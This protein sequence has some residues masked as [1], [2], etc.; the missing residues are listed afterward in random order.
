MKRRSMLL[1][2]LM[3]LLSVG[4]VSADAGNVKVRFTGVEDGDKAVLSIASGEYLSTL[5]VTAD[6]SYEFKDVP[7]GRHSVKAEAPGYNVIEA[8][9]VVVNEDGSVIP[10]E[11]LRVAI[12]KQSAD[13]NE[14]NFTWKEDDSPAGYTTTSYINKPVEIDFLGKKIVPSGVPS[15]NILQNQYHILL[16][17]DEEQWT[18]EYAYR[19]V[20][21][22]KTLPG[23]Y[24]DRPYA[25]FTLTSGHIADD[26]TVAQ[27]DG[28]YEV[29]ISKDAFYYA[30]PFLV[31][32]DGV[33]GRL[34]S[35]RLH[36]AM[37]NFVTDFGRDEGRVNQI[38]SERFGCQIQ[39]V[40]YEELTR[41]ITDEDAGRFQPFVPSELVAIINMFEELPEGFHK[42]PHLNYL[43]RRINGMKHPI[44]P[45]AAAV[46][47][48]VDNG[49]IEFM[50]N[51]FG[52]NNQSFDTQRLILHEK[53]HFLWAY[54]FSE[55]IRRDWIKVGGWYED[56]NAGEGWSTTKDVE[57]VSAYAHAKNPNEDMAES[58]AFYLKN[59]DKL[60]SRSLEKYEFIRDRIMHGT[61][62]I[63]KIPDH[64]TFEVLN[65][66]PDYDYP[67][68]IKSVD[69]SVTGAPEED[70]TIT[71]QV[72]L[73][74]LDGF[75]DGASTGIVRITGP[76]FI[77]ENGEIHEQFVDLHLN[78]IDG[79]NHLL[80][81][82]A[83][84]S[85]YS[86]AGHW[87]GG[88]I[89]L[90]D[91]QGN[92]RFEGRND[93]VTDYYI[94]NPLEDLE[95][96]KYVGD[97]RYIL[98]D[99]IVEG[100]KAQNLQVRYK[101]TDNI[102]IRSVY[103]AMTCSAGE[104]GYEKYGYYDE[105]N[106]EGVVDFII[107]EYF[108]TGDYWI[109]NLFIDDFAGTSKY[110]TFSDSP[111][112]MPIQKIY[113]ETE[114]P[115][116][117]PVEIDLNRITVYAEPT[118]P[119]APDGETLV[120]I[121]FY[122]R[123]DKSGFGLCTYDLRD[124]QGIDHFQW[125][126]HRNSSNMFFDGDPT[127]WER[128]TIKCVLPQGS[129]PGIW[130]L[131]DITPHDKAGN[132][133]TY[134]F[135]ETLIFEPDDSDSDYVLFSELD[136]NDMLSIDLQGTSG[137]MFGFTWRIIHEESGK[138]INGASDDF[139]AENARKARL[140]SVSA[141]RGASVDV[142]ALDDGDL[143][144]IVTAL[145]AEGKVVAVKTKRLLKDSRSAIDSVIIGNDTPVTVYNLQGIAV[146]VNVDANDWQ[147]GLPA[148]IYIVDG[149][150]YLIK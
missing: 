74:H 6:G 145:N 73:N 105:E 50:E 52:G 69:I 138:E 119:E 125:F 130:G 62:Y 109:S 51:A 117:T 33:R 87:S 103:C 140:R 63:S 93:C 32:L 7:A 111:Q 42:T 70:K 43:I 24:Y 86:K 89:V 114:N 45:E 54:T 135:V 64:L 85:R 18:Q 78:P 112:D 107:T 36:H 39:N 143:I 17:D 68:K 110:V 96:P 91:M 102:G 46:S 121:N 108:P 67:G 59:P 128:Y 142:S 5:T 61:R 57:F 21:T 101:T 146:K 88:D 98:T 71:L 37:T 44:Y 134:N 34:F 60:R 1:L 47:W 133:F 29:R 14:W 113:I 10:S 22:L 106:Q 35:K 4:G 94:N 25:K 20:E 131:A 120:T 100:H 92:Q 30:N 150:K 12:T 126:Y 132:V 141:R 139:A 97:L 55:E 66:Y 116:T 49:Y 53:T 8:L 127:V 144:V 104:Y 129:A 15:A 56:P 124:P 136:A 31:S 115:D 38:L 19:M 81:G 83:V 84:V 137:E 9:T 82:T 77:G 79:N 65:L 75:D 76:R 41:G 3:A 16:V 40:N 11:P 27:L 147:N 122:A 58:V 148:G 90:T 13:P 72:E 80:S 28:G 2:L 149:K 118:H 48:C 99:T 26:I 123:D 95:A 23:W